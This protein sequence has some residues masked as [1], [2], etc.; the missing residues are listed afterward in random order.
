MALSAGN[1]ASASDVLALVATDSPTTFTTTTPAGSGW[2]RSLL[3]GQLV[4]FHWNSTG[5]V[6]AG[7]DATPD[8]TIPS[9]Y[10]PAE[11]TPIAATSGSTAARVAAADVRADGT[12]RVYNDYTVASI[13]NA[14]GIYKPA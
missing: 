13:I 14:H 2:Y 3:G 6:A 8:F 12:W 5:T 9:G 4:E 1:E 7:G 11:R 10:R